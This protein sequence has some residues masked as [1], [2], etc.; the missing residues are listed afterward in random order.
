[1]ALHLFFRRVSQKTMHPSQKNWASFLI[2]SCES[3]FWAV[4]FGRFFTGFH[5]KSFHSFSPSISRFGQLPLGEK[6]LGFVPWGLPPARVM[7]RQVRTPD[8]KQSGWGIF[9]RKGIERERESN[10]F[11]WLC[12]NFG[13]FHSAKCRFDFFGPDTVWFGFHNFGLAEII[14]LWTIWATQSQ[15]TG[16]LAQKV[17]VGMGGM[18]RVQLLV[19]GSGDD[20]D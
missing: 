13:F 15:V 2:C 18:W 17:R 6:Q 1:M 14:N 5:E 12:I 11:L 3:Q 7:V 4:S 19:A 9:F 20:G 16:A 10:F 8:L